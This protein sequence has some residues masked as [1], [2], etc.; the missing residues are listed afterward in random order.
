MRPSSQGA[1]VRSAAVGSLLLGGAVAVG[2]LLAR[3]PIRLQAVVVGLVAGAV[4][5]GLGEVL[6]SRRA[7]S[8]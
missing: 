5:F 3:E 6:R 7:R 1:T 8:K 4:F 2:Y